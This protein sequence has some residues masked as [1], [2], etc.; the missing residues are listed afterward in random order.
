MSTNATSFHVESLPPASP[1]YEATMDSDSTDSIQ[2]SS[3]QDTLDHDITEL[4]QKLASE[5]Q[6]GAEH[7]ITLNRLGKT[8]SALFLRTRSN[9]ALDEAIS[10]HQNAVNLVPHDHQYRFAYLGDLGLCLH[11]RYRERGLSADAESAVLILRQALSISLAGD[12]MDSRDRAERAQIFACL[13]DVFRDRFHTTTQAR[14]DLDEAIRMFAEASKCTGSHDPDYPLYLVD[15]ANAIRERHQVFH[16]DPEALGEAISILEEAMAHL[17][18]KG[19]TNSYNIRRCLRELGDLLCE[20]FH[21][22]GKEEDLNRAVSVFERAVAIRLDDGSDQSY[23]LHCLGDTLILRFTVCGDDPDFYKGID[24]L[25]ESLLLRPAGHPGRFNS[26]ESLGKAYQ[27]Y[28][29]GISSTDRGVLDQ[30]IIYVREALSCS[31]AGRA[32]GVILDDLARALLTRSEHLEYVSDINEALAMH[33]KAADIYLAIDNKVQY[34]E[35][36]PKIARALMHRYRKISMQQGLKDL[37]EAIDLYTHFLQASKPHIQVTVYGLLGEALYARFCD[38][39]SR[40]L[41]DLHKAVD[42]LRRS[43][44]QFSRPEDNY[45][46]VPTLAKALH[47][48][49]HEPVGC[50]ENYLEALKRLEDAISSLPHYVP[51]QYKLKFPLSQLYLCDMPETHFLTAME[52]MNEVFG[53]TPASPRELVE[54]VQ[55]VFCKAEKALSSMEDPLFQKRLELA[56]NYQRA[57]ALLLRSATLNLDIDTRLVSLKAGEGFA[58][59]GANHF[60]HM[61][62]LDTCIEILEDGRGVFWSL[63]LLLRSQFDELAQVAPELAPK[64]RRISKEL[65][66]SSPAFTDIPSMER[67]ASRRRQ[68]GEEFES[69][70]GRIK[71][72][73]L[74]GLQS[75]REIASGGPVVLILPPGELLGDFGYCR[76]IVLRDEH[77]SPEEVLFPSLNQSAVR[78]MCT[79]CSTGLTGQ[80]SRMGDGRDTGRIEEQVM[81]LKVKTG[82][83]D[84]TML[85]LLSQLWNVVVRPIVR[86]LGLKKAY[87]RDRP[88]LWW[89]PIGTFA[90][91]PFHAAGIYPQQGDTQECCSDYFVSSY[92]PTLKALRNARVRQSKQCEASSVKFFLTAVPQAPGYQPLDSVISELEIVKKSI[93]DQERHIISLP[94][95][96]TGVP[97][98]KA[99]AML[100]EAAVLHFCS[101]GIQDSSNPLQS[102]FVFPD[103]LLTVS[104]LM[105]LEMPNAQFA[106]LSACETAMGDKTRPDQA[107]HLAAAMLH[108][109]LSSVVG[110][111]WSMGDMDGPEIAFK[112]YKTIIT[113]LPGGHWDLD[114]D[115]VPYALDS[116]IQ[117]L[118]RVAR[119]EQWATYIHVGA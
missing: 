99:I 31:P 38:S 118:R 98:E 117:D 33:R 29:D 51:G 112:I 30:A 8:L 54:G 1:V 47:D 14:E 77:S 79:K 92:I 58:L 26:L 25:H 68:L 116:A 7:Y 56:K 64:L 94:N 2:Q 80:R 73:S 81:R 103:G 97:V 46:F 70:M 22:E 57:V 50:H 61:G 23:D 105:E 42:M 20:Q 35:S 36:K 45:F 11:D 53:D 96:G 12:S 41:D 86:K 27:E 59:A 55:P 49:S 32:H 89:C 66:A 17:E 48:L 63:G 39:P 100:P 111:M 82:T 16:S 6:T 4:R 110:T 69:E 119:P 28:Y 78:D 13:G 107:I 104:K 21:E 74:F 40:P 37:D 52:Y 65:S 43:L 90:F 24:R 84:R 15:R 76:A 95:G 85:Q 44:S 109:G 75:F 115:S 87:G 18:S 102:G 71:G 62:Q 19:E 83:D 108:V 114:L 5:A 9:E 3:R 10:K 106:F 101:H 93:P 72:H 60:A 34:T 88:R 67:E 91:L 113:Q